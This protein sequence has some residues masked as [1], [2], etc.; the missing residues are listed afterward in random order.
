MPEY[1]NSFSDSSDFRV[2]VV[3]A[4]VTGL[5]AAIELAE[6][7]VPVLLL[8]KGDVGGEQSNYALGWVRT[9][10]RQ[11]AEI[12]V[13]LLNRARF[14]ALMPDAARLAYGVLFCAKDEAQRTRLEQWA[15]VAAQYGV[16]TRLLDAAGTAARLPGCTVGTAGALLTEVDTSIDP[17]RL[18]QALVARATALGVEILTRRA[19]RALDMTAGAVRGVVTETGIERGAAVVLATGAWTRLVLQGAGYTLPSVK[20]RS[21]LVRI[22]TAARLPPGFIGCA[23]VAGVG[24][25]ADPDGTVVVGL[26]S[27]NRLEVTPDALRFAPR[28]LPMWWAHRGEISPSLGR[29]FFD[30]LC[31]GRGSYQGRTS[32]YEQKRTLRPEPRRALTQLTISRFAELF[33]LLGDIEPVESWAGYL[34]MTPDGLPVIS[35]V[36]RT[37][38]LFVATGLNGSGLGTGLAVGSLVASL[39]MGRTPETDVSPF[40][41]DRWSR[42]AQPAGGNPEK[43]AAQSTQ[44]TTGLP[45]VAGPSAPTQASSC[46][47]NAPQ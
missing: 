33:P 23:G 7:G 15:D 18:V 11:P 4:G 45:G 13:S 41:L 35:A 9:T 31:V 43:H 39:V 44:A 3:G 25:R 38:G 29:T 22:R 1:S 6:A 42:L 2:I 14:D 46:T 40:R 32:A 8:E 34:D 30:E 36:E 47:E 37:P 17:R 21:S 26:E 12:P 28:Y 10:G 5:S 20:V 19:V 27:G 24:Y 16:K